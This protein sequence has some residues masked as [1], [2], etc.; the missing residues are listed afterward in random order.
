MYLSFS[1]ALPD[2]DGRRGFISPMSALTWQRL[3]LCDECL[4]EPPGRLDLVALSTLRSSIDEQL[5][6]VGQLQHRRR[7]MARA[8]VRLRRQHAHTKAQR[9]LRWK[10]KRAYRRE[11]EA[12]EGSR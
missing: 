2:V 3:P 10:L 7:W 12:M 8:Y 6:M 1:P 5:A 11:A 4:D 9:A